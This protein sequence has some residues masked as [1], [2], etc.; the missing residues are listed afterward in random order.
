MDNKLSKIL[1]LGLY[2]LLGISVLVTII[3]FYKIG[4]TSP[5]VSAEEEL[6]AQNTAGYMIT[7]WSYVLL[8][9]ATLSV[10]VFPVMQMVKNPKQAKKTGISIGIVAIAV[11]IAFLIASGE[12]PAKFDGKISEAGVRW[13]ETALILTYGLGITAILAIIYS[14]IAKIF[15]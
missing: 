3:F 8:G 15:K 12:V 13:S 2:I 4:Q 1:S 5:S 6:V 14:G 11:L 9:I 7:M 10:I